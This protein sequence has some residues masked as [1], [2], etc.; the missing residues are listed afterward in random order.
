MKIIDLI[1]EHIHQ[2]KDVYGYSPT[3]VQL[4]KKEYY[5]FIV[6]VDASGCLSEKVVG[7]RIQPH[8]FGM[9]IKEVDRQSYIEVS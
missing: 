1:L 8:I 6:W 4:G 7:A 9:L 5:E 3:E 2:F